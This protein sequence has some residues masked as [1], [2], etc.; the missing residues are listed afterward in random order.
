[1]PTSFIIDPR[2]KFSLQELIQASTTSGFW[3]LSP[4]SWSR[5]RRSHW[6]LLSILKSGRSVYGIH[7]GFGSLQTQAIDA[8]ELELHQRELVASHACGL[9]D[10][11]DASQVRALMYLRL[12]Q[13]GRGFSGISERAA[14]V[15]LNLANS[16]YLPR[17]P[18]QGSVGACGDLIPMAHVALQALK[19]IPRGSLGPRDGLAMI[20]GTEAALAVSLLA[21]GDTQ[22]LFEAVS[23]IA[24]LTLFSISGKTEAWEP[25]FTRL[26]NHADMSVV[27]ERLI[28]LL[29]RYK[30]G[31]LP[32]DPYSLRAAPHLLGAASRALAF[33][34]D[35]LSEEA[36]SITDNPVFLDKPKPHARHGAHFHGIHVA[37]A[38]D[39][40]AWALNLL[41]VAS[42][43]RVDYLL[44]GKHGLPAMLA[45]RPKSSGL[46]IVH[47]AQAALVAENRLLSNPASADSIPTSA[48]QE[49]VVPMAMGAALKL[50]RAAANTSRILAAEALA[51]G[52]ALELSGRVQELR[53]KTKLAPF[54]DFLMKAAG[55]SWSLQD[56]GFSPALE[57]IAASL[58]C[59]EPQEK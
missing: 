26:K 3:D 41:G 56:Q 35:M 5:I 28:S 8:S 50:Q 9:G 51:A 59:L 49:D 32:Q 23:K 52:R 29:G 30:N 27:S 12:R 57:T 40:G 39:L 4:V 46:M 33:G 24:A 38:A 25:S 13:W 6:A 21:F 37:L 15:Y 17:V 2:K 36:E 22:A 31:G 44:S 53:R 48:G 47:V 7:T 14:R 11:L 45:A 19:R 55:S 18:S 16:P 42:E 54:V 10:P 34:L 20:N 1:M 43:R 58:R